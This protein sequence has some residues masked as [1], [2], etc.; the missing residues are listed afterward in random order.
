MK[1]GDWTEGFE[2]PRSLPRDIRD[3]LVARSRVIRARAGT[4]VFGPDNVP[5]S[6]L[7]LLEGTLR[8][9]QTSEGGREIVLYRAVAGESCVLTTA[10]V[11]TEEAHAAEGIAETDVVAAALPVAVFDE[12]VAQAPAFRQFVI[13]AYRKRLQ[14][15]LR[16]IDD[17]AFGRIDMRLAARLLDLAAGEVKLH[18]THQQLA[19]ELGTA[20][21]VISRQLHEFQRRGWIGQTRGQIELKDRPALDR[22]AHAFDKGHAD[23]E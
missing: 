12:L 19:V 20:R 16:V 7:F 1:V 6:L 10:C 9:S 23:F 15:L 22:L 17:V 18:V 21:E 3:R 2:G 13:A 5:D 4:V 8:V 11:L 14:D